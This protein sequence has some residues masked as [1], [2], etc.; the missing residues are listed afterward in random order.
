MTR[1]T[2]TTK[3]DIYQEITDKLIVIIEQ[4]VLPWQ[5]EYSL[6]G[7]SKEYGL[8]TRSTGEYYQGINALYLWA[9]RL[10]KNYSSQYWFTYKQA[11]ELNAHVKK[12]EK[13][14]LV[15]Y[16]STFTKE[17]EK[18]D[19]T[20]EQK[21]PFLK[22]YSVFNAN[23]IE[24]L[25]KK[26]YQEHKLPDSDR[27]ENAEKFIANTQAKIT[28]SAPKPNPCYTPA[29]DQIY[30]PHIST[31]FTK[32]NYYS[33]VFHELGHWTGHKDRLARVGIVGEKSKE[34]YAIE[35]LIAELS[36]A[37]TMA[38]LG[39]TKEPLNN[40]ASYLDSWLQAL[41][42]DKKWIFTAASQAQKATE[43]LKGLQPD[44]KE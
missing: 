33:T 42:N 24:G 13:S 16:G 40:H 18:K 25:P 41:K 2:E 10:V 27:I 9:E 4:G 5:R 12:G 29:I 15:V 32:E 1:T 3:K 22:S 8:P 39:V 14:S 11:Q 36:A 30:V 37:Y 7:T 28:N 23:Q 34:N 31:Y 6:E 19:E 43:Y 38:Y 17:V 35:E 20:I 26:Y 21:I 44:S